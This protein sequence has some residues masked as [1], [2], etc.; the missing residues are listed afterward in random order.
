MLATIDIS[1]N[2]LVEAEA[3]R[4][5]RE[6]LNKLFYNTPSKQ[7]N[8]GAYNGL[9][10]KEK[11][12]PLV[13]YLLCVEPDVFKET[14]NISDLNAVEKNYVLNQV[15]DELT[16]RIPDF[17]ADAEE[18]VELGLVQVVI[19]RA[20]QVEE[21]CNCIKFGLENIEEAFMREDALFLG[22]PMLCDM[23]ISLKGAVRNEVMAEIIDLK[24]KTDNLEIKEKCSELLSKKTLWECI[25]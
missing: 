10:L 9:H 21:E 3:I 22:Y 16:I 12:S 5:Q 7:E 11:L 24:E 2:V 4:K 25:L 8:S 19:N 6:Q 20:H 1:S 14:M 23:L 15:A 17:L 13:E 18:I